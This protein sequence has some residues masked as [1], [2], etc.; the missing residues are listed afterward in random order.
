MSPSDKNFLH[1]PA[2]GEGV[3]GHLLNLLGLALVKALV[4]Q[5]VIRHVIFY[6]CPGFTL[7]RGLALNSAS[8]CSMATM[9]CFGHAR[10][11]AAAYR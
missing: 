7:R 10:T 1:G 9:F 4:H 8:A 2:L 5:G 11:G 6:S 3:L